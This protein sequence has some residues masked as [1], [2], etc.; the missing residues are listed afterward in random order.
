MPTN[1]KPN[2]ANLIA[3]METRSRGGG[4]DIRVGVVVCVLGRKRG[5]GLN[6]FWYVYTFFSGTFH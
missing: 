3:R 5:V 6:K 4:R 2:P 1:P